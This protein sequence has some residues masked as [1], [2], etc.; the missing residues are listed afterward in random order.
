MNKELHEHEHHH[1]DG[2]C[3]GHEHEHH[4][5]TMTIAAV[6]MSI[7]SMTT[8]SITTLQRIFRQTTRQRFIPLKIWVVPTVPQRWRA[9][10]T[11]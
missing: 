5:I 3:C 9:G 4:I 8:M 11:S 10:L 7:T 1:D 2:C 6:D